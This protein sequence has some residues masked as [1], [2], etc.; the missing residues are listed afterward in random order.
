MTA[1]KKPGGKP[2]F[3]CT[4]QMYI[5]LTDTTANVGQ[6]CEA[7]RR[8]W[9]SEYTIVS[10]EGLEIDDTLATQGRYCRNYD[11]QSQY[12]VMVFS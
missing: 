8:Q 11:M 7:V 2:E 1:A 6:V 10:V 5:E 9:G 3:Q 12:D 4:G